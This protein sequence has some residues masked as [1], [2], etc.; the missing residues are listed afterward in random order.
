[1]ATLLVKVDAH[2]RLSVPAARNAAWRDAP[3]SVKSRFVPDY[4][5]DGL[6][7]GGPGQTPIIGHGICGDKADQPQDHMEGGKFGQML[8]G[9]APE[10]TG[11]YRPGEPFDIGIVLTAHHDGFFEFRLCDHPDDKPWDETTQGCLDQHVLQLANPQEGMPKNKWMYNN[12][13]PQLWTEPGARST[14]KWQ[15]PNADSYAFIDGGHAYSM[16]YIMPN[17]ECKRCTLQWY[18][19]T[20]NS[21][22]A[23]PEEFWNC[24]DIQVTTGA[25]SLTPKA[26]EA[27]E[28]VEQQLYD[29]TLG[30]CG[31]SG[32]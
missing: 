25:L 6:A 10:I 11:S 1:L 17:V 7:A 5:L 12:V 23:Y 20:G 21:P 32:T 2:G 19:Q 24:A 30:G 14:S 16:Q 4:N 22:I 13:H 15:V 29:Q 26:F 3:D 28:F 31:I 9:G 8:N 27:S 18:Y